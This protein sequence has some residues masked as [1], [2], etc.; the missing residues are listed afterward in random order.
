MFCNLGLYWWPLESPAS[1]GPVD[2]ALVKV[3]GGRWGQRAGP[4]AFSATQGQNMILTALCHSVYCQLLTQPLTDRW[5][6]SYAWKQSNR[7]TITKTLS[8]R[9]VF[10]SR[11]TGNIVDAFCP[12]NAC[13]SGWIRSARSRARCMR[14]GATLTF[15]DLETTNHCPASPPVTQ[16]HQNICKSADCHVPKR[17]DSWSKCVRWNLQTSHRIRRYQTVKSNPYVV[18]TIWQRPLIESMCR[19]QLE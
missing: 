17:L 5:R 11:Q 3:G 14:R 8:F 13:Y 9:F 1:G 4:V 15:V 2:T 12:R 6:T 19:I 18:S 10:F 16:S 7:S